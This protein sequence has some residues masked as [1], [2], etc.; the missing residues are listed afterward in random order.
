VEWAAA[1]KKLNSLK[2]QPGDIKIGGDGKR[3]TLSSIK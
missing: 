3:L 2:I 1:N